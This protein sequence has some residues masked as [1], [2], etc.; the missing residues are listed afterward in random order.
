[1]LGGGGE[2]VRLA[3]DLSV[4]H[5][6]EVR[7]FVRPSLWCCAERARPVTEQEGR[8]NVDMGSYTLGHGRVAGEPGRWLA[9][10]HEHTKTHRGSLFYEGLALC[11]YPLSPPLLSYEYLL[12]VAVQ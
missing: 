8:P 1:M 11:H 9:G 7:V 10:V 3:S 4:T 5:R 2:L 12:P 6:R